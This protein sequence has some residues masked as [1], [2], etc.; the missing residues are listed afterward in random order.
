MPRVRATRP[1]GE[2]LGFMLQTIP[3]HLLLLQD[4]DRPVLMTIGNVSEE[5]PPVIDGGEARR[6][7]AAIA[8]M[9]QINPAATIP[10]VSSRTGAGTAEWYDWLRAQC[11]AARQSAFA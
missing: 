7:L 4:I 11:A 2:T 5:Q 8:N 1:I 6:R 3:V 9:R 10:Q